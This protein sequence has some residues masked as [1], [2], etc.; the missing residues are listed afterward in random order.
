MYLSVYRFGLDLA[1]GVR[2][3]DLSRDFR[4]DPRFLAVFVDSPRGSEHIDRSYIR[5]TNR[6]S[7]NRLSRIL[8]LLRS[9]SRATRSLVALATSATPRRSNVEIPRS[10]DNN[11]P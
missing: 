1:S 10:R 3:I 9:A 6:A 2:A 7:R 8:P 4:S 11:V 5:D